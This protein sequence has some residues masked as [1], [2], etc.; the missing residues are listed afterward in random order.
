[1]IES[2][3]SEVSFATGTSESWCV[4]FGATNHICNLLQGFRE[5]RRLSDG[6]IIVD[7]GS[8]AKADAISVG[9]ITLCFSN[10]KLI[11]SDTLYVLSLRRNLISISSLV[12]KSYSITFGTE[13]VIKRNGTFI[14]SGKIIIGLYLL[15]PTMYEIHHT[16]IN[17][18]L[19]LK[20][21][22][23]FI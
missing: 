22:S 23:P 11:L 16:E 15:T 20:R 9:V 12:N 1:M 5:T 7:L 4:D 18:R 8:E 19:S 21:K 13:V 17:N 14:C 3:V 2:L 6:E 10:N